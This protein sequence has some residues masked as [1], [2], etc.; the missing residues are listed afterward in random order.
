MAKPNLVKKLKWILTV[1]KQS[2]LAV[3]TLL[4]LKKSLLEELRSILTYLHSGKTSRRHLLV[5][6]DRQD[7]GAVDKAL[8]V[9][10][11]V[12][13]LVTLYLAKAAPIERS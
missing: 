4:T 5:D 12:K 8:K 7:I 11:L 13:V 9:T 3:I 6:E 2:T 10:E 1:L